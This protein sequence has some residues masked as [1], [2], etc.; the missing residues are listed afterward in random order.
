M[1]VGVIGGGVVGMCCARELSAAGAEVTVIERGRCGE[2]TSYRNAGQIVPSLAAPLATPGIA[3]QALRYLADLNSPL[4]IRPT[5]DLSLLCWLW[6]FAR[7]SSRRR[8]TECIRAILSLGEH[9][10]ELFE[11]MR[12]EGVRFETHSEGMLFAAMTKHGFEEEAR[13]YA[14]IKS[15]GYCGEIKVLDA[16]ALHECEPALSDNVIAALHVTSE[17]HIRP[18]TLA[19]GLRTDI[20]AKGV[21]VREGAQ[22][23]EVRKRWNRGWEIQTDDHAIVVDAVVIAAG[24]WSKPLL[25]GLG[26]NL[27]LQAGKGLSITSRGTGTPPRHPIKFIEAQIVTSPFEGAVRISGMFDLAGSDTS[28]NRHRIATVER[29]AALYFRDWRPDTDRIEWAGLRPATPDSLPLIGRVL[30]IED[31]YLA[32]GHGMLG[33]TLAPAT[34]H[35]LVP[36]I[37]EGRCAPE[38]MPFRPDRFAL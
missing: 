31:L 9:T 5:T 2:A 1:K 18:E 38:L 26:L 34:A 37:L 10:H 21:N 36:L 20:L 33:V 13:I 15:A 23:K 29:A 6:F 28:I 17:Q 25:R 32:T 24:V 12:A 19:N 8:Y 11:Q 16:D 30:G 4:R 3:L 27:P 7:S 22:V 35:S 14:D